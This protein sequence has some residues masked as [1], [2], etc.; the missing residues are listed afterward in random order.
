MTQVQ[1][2][3]WSRAKTDLRKAVEAIFVKAKKIRNPDPGNEQ[4]SP[5][6]AVIHG[7]AFVVQ[8][9]PRDREEVLRA[10]IEALDVMTED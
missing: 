10:L 9:Y 1:D 6:Q 5:Q 4:H 2:R 7:L 8:E 3:A